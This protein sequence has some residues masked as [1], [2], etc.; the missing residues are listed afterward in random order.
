[1]K[2]SQSDNL[3]STKS[4]GS[5]EYDYTGRSVEIGFGVQVEILI[6]E[7]RFS[8]FRSSWV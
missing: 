1:V 4:G 2:N 7:E 3:R 8:D 5:P 6:P